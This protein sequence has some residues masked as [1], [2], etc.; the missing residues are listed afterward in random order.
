[1]VL[2]RRRIHNNN[3]LLPEKSH[4]AR[5]GTLFAGSVVSGQRV[6][7]VGTNRTRVGFVL[8]IAP[9]LELSGVASERCIPSVP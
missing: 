1:M 9:L 2:P 7:F 3:K 6:G 8:G 5:M 4:T